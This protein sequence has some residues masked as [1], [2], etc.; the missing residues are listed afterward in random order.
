MC[1][2]LVSDVLQTDSLSRVAFTAIDISVCTLITE[3]VGISSILKRHVYFSPRISQNYLFDPPSI[4]PIFL[5]ATN[6]L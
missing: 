2:T 3:L 6:F 1:Q 5:E 4:T